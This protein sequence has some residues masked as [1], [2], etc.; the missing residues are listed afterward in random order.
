MAGSA[1]QLQTAAPH[2]TILELLACGLEWDAARQVSFEEA[3]CLLSLQAHRRA[4][5]A[6]DAESAR[7]ASLAFTDPS[8]LGRALTGLSLRAGAMEHRFRR[9]YPPRRGSVI[10]GA[11]DE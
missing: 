4:L 5:A 9:D 10:E 2:E 1:T 11:C 8:E 3:Q 7:I 6:L